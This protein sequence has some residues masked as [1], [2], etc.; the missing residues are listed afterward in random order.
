MDDMDPRWRNKKKH[1]FVLS[2]AG[3]PIFSRYGDEN[4]LAGFF[5]SI[6]AMISF[7]QDNGDTLHSVRAGDH[8]VSGFE[9]GVTYSA[10][11]FIPCEDP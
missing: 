11:R 6:Q 10:W 1:V 3:K 2:H 5:A 4:A 8:W 7:V 9:S